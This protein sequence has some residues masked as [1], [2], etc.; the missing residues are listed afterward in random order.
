MPGDGHAD[1]MRTVRGNIIESWHASR[2]P[3]NENDAG[4]DYEFDDGDDDDDDRL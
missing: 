2:E 1:L 4:G 3:G